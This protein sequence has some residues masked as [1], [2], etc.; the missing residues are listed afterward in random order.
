M[1]I[2]THF[3]VKKLVPSVAV[4]HLRFRAAGS[5]CNQQL[6]KRLLI[7]LCLFLNSQAG[8]LSQGRVRGEK[9]KQKK[10]AR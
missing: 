3:P 4:S 6:H 1:M 7:S 2:L 5:L 8:D 10:T 9:K